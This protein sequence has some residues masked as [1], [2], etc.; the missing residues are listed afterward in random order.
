MRGEAE[1]VHR[2]IDA[3]EE[4][5][6][7]LR[8]GPLAG[9]FSELERQGAPGSLTPTF[10]NTPCAEPRCSLFDRMD[11]DQGAA[12]ELASAAAAAGAEPIAKRARS[13]EPE[14][15]ERGNAA[16]TGEEVAADVEEEEPAALKE[17]THD[18]LRKVAKA[19]LQA[20][21]AERGLEQTGSVSDLNAFAQQD[22]ALR[23]EAV[24]LVHQLVLSE[25][26]EAKQA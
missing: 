18:D 1:A 6:L 7:S 8:T 11:M 16:G 24:G 26:F 10:Q 20:M 15:G 5:L 4:H 21:C 25:A 9:V 2:R 22:R 17:F 19:D 23:G 13:A 3:A 12:A 14:G